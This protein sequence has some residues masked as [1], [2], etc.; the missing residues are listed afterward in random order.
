MSS[1]TD[2]LRQNYNP[3]TQMSLGQSMVIASAIRSSGPGANVLIFGCGNDS[4][5]WLSSN[6]AGYTMFVEDNPAWAK[7]TRRANPDMNIREISYGPV[8]VETSLPVDEAALSQN[9]LPAFLRERKWDVIL[10][11]APAGSAPDKPGRALPIY[12]SSL[13][14]S[15]TTHV[16]IDDYT[17]ELERTYGDHFFRSR[18]PWH[19]RRS[20]RSTCTATDLDRRLQERR[21]TT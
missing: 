16:F 4:G 5:L 20:R 7:R 15:D 3:A 13:I 10:I 11:D 19:I 18:R 2:L 14:A 17:R 1:L 12:W 6:E 8:S 9:A 21:R